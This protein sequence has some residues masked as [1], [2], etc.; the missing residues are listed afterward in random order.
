MKNYFL[1]RLKTKTHDDANFAITGGT[2][3]PT[4]LPVM[5]KLVS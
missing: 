3:Q 4:V 5:T 2:W 1:S